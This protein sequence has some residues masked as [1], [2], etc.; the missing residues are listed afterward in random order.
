MRR[1]VAIICMLCIM[2]TCCNAEE[3]KIHTL[4]GIDFDNM[5]LQQVHDYLDQEKGIQ[6]KI[7]K[8]YRNLRTLDSQEITLHGY[9]FT[10]YYDEYK[11]CK[12]IDLDFRSVGGRDDAYTIVNAMIDK[13]GKPTFVY[14]DMYSKSDFEWDHNIGEPMYHQARIVDTINDFN[15]YDTLVNW[16]HYEENKYHWGSIILYLYIDNIKIKLECSDTDKYSMYVVYYSVI[17]SVQIEEVDES[18]N[19]PNYTDTGF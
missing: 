19:V 7:N 6:S 9:P 18:R 8:Q 3:S 4:W 13:Y 15:M 12:A 16:E 14:Y 10:L 17:P 11:D 5:T 1:I 2:I